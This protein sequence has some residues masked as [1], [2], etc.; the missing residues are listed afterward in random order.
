MANHSPNL[1]TYYTIVAWK[2]F[3]VSVP[4]SKNELENAI[5]AGGATSHNPKK[6]WGDVCERAVNPAWRAAY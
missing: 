3:H 4:P 2:E 6:P 1:I 5:K